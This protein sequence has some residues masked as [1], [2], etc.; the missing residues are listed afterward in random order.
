MSIKCLSLKLS[1]GVVSMLSPWESLL[2]K[3]TKFTEPTPPPPAP[4]P[5]IIIH[6]GWMISGHET[7]FL[8]LNSCPLANHA[9]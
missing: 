8:S 6:V 9:S 4:N 1:V 5:L 2:I 7:R 3:K